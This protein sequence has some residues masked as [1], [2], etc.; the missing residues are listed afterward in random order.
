MISKEEVKKIAKLARLSLAKDEEESFQKELSSILD[1]FNLLKEVDTSKVEP[2]FHP[3]EKNLLQ[4]GNVFR[5]DISQKD[6]EEISKK[7]I[8]SV[9]DKSENRIKVKTIL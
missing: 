6:S 1:Y 9:P 5:E 3:T 2:T 4:S 8:E 7:L